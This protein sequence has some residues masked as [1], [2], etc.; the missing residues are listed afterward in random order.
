MPVAMGSIGIMVCFLVRGLLPGNFP[1]IQLYAKPVPKGKCDFQAKIAGWRI[2]TICVD[3]YIYKIVYR[4]TFLYAVQNTKG[5]AEAEP[6]ICQQKRK[7]VRDLSWNAFG[8]STGSGT[9][10]MRF[11]SLLYAMTLH[12]LTAHEGE[13]R[14][15]ARL[16]MT[17][18]RS[19]QPQAAPRPRRMQR[20]NSFAHC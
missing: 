2:R 12:S 18:P 9:L 19:R 17:E 1:D 20:A 8:P 10:F 4:N 11:C 15:R 5:P 6:K 16:H 13:S 3:G 7:W 14:G